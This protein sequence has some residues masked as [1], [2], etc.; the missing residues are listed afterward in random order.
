[1]QRDDLPLGRI[2]VWTNALDAQPAGQ[3]Q[4]AVGELEALGFGA[5]WI[6]ESLGRE[7]LTNSMLLLAGGERI[8][9][10]TG[11]ANLWARDPVAMANAHKTVTSAYPGR[12]LLGIGVSHRPMVENV[13]GHQYDKPLSTT[14]AYLEAMDAAPF[15]GAP[16]PTE[17]V[18]V[19]A[20]L[21]PRMLELSVSHAAGAHPYFVT[22]DHTAGARAILGDGALLCPEQ[23]VVL[24]TDPGRARDIARAHTRNYLALP[25]YVANLRRLGF[26]DTD[27][28][29]AGSDRLVDA[30]V[31][32]GDLDAVKARVDAHLEAGADHVC[33]QVLADDPRALP[34]AGWREV[35]SALAAA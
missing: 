9:V 29:D 33:V 27:V 10:A 26:D 23:A 35:A 1:M 13:R 11:I 21:R 32:W 19:L 24:E 31:A 30:I 14:R 25:N 15:R 4:E 6:P 3:A 12:F 34:M 20:A 18:R 5:V 28:L 2:G 16:P 22:P 8:V 7:A 17:P